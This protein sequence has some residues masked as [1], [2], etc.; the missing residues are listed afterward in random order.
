MVE[1]RSPGLAALFTMEKNMPRV[2]AYLC[3]HDI[4]VERVNREA[5]HLLESGRIEEIRL[6]SPQRPF[7][8]IRAML[9]NLLRAAPLSDPK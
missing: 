3:M 9:T 5:L 6:T 8:W 1:W 2:H 7:G 4:S